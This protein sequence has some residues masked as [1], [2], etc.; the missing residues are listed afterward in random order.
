VRFALALQSN[1]GTLAENPL[2]SPESFV[3]RLADKRRRLARV[4]AAFTVSYEQLPEELRRSWRSLSVFPGSF[5]TKQA[6]NLWKTSEDAAIDTLGRLH[7]SSMLEYD[8]VGGRMRMHDLARAFA[9]SLVST[10]EK[11]ATAPQKL[12]HEASHDAA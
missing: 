1:A 9:N 10:E 4:E 12:R 8:S 2:L 11:S 5:D 6:A 3:T 7:R